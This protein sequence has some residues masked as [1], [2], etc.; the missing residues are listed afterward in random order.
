MDYVL[1]F[2]DSNDPV[3]RAQYRLINISDPKDDSRF[4]PFDTLKYAFRSVAKNM[5]F[6]DR[7]VLIVST[8]SQ[9][10]SWVNRD[11]VKVI[12]H[13]RFMPKDHLPTFSSSAIESDMWR[14][15]GLSER[16]VYGND[17]FFALRPMKE[18]DFFDGNLPRLN[19]E[20]SDYHVVNV[21]RISCRNG[22][23]MAADAAGHARTDR[24]TLLKPQHCMKGILNRHMKEV[25]RICGDAIDKTVT[26]RRHPWNVTGYIYHYYAMYIG[27]YAEF[28]KTYT[29]IRI[30]NDY[31]AVTDLIDHPQSDLLCINDA[32][33]LDGEHYGAACA[34]LAASFERLFPTRC[35][36]ELSE[37]NNPNL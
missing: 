12:T 35:Q 32:G 11:K 31:K 27:E 37:S 10:P 9:V 8:E 5:P 29:Y 16:F 26:I 18:T 24:W 21:F 22:M 28:K 19:F 25:G 13:D 6:I 15:D 23:D 7:I 33:D 2:V 3:W 20:A 34:A 17:D 1:P 14:I 4:R 36:Y 30:T